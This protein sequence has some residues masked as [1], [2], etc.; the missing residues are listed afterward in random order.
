VAD[1]VAGAGLQVGLDGAP[2]ADAVGARA[3]LEA[4]EAAAYREKAEALRAKYDL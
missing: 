2:V 1:A 3:A 4:F